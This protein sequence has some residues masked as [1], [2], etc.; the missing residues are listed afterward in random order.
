MSEHVQSTDLNS[1]L[2][3]TRGTSRRDAN[4]LALADQIQFSSILRVLVDTPEQT[5][6]VAQAATQSRQQDDR[7]PETAE[8]DDRPVRKT[9]RTRAKERDEPHARRVQEPRSDSPVTVAP[10]IT[11]IP[12]G[13][14]PPVDLGA[15][16]RALPDANRIDRS[17]WR[18]RGFD[19]DAL[20]TSPAATDPARILA[21]D[22]APDDTGATVAKTQQTILTKAV[23]SMASSALADEHFS[24]VGQDLHDAVMR[25]F[26]NVGQ[27][28]G[29]PTAASS[30]KDQQEVDL[31]SRLNA[32]APVAIQVDLAGDAAKTR[33]NSL[34]SL[35]SGTSLAAFEGLD[36]DA[37]P[38]A[39][40]FG[41]SNGEASGSETKA[42]THGNLLPDRPIPGANG[43][44]AS[45]NQVLRAQGALIA[46]QQAGQA[47]S[48]AK[49]PVL[50][51]DV[52]Q[53]MGAAPSGPSQVSQ[54]A[55][56]NA[57]SAARQPERPQPP[58][59]QIAVKIRQAVSEGLDKIN[60]KLNPANLGRVEVRLEIKDGHIAAT[61]LA[62]RKET[63]DLLQRDARGLERALLDAGLR[64]DI[65]S[66]SFGL[67]GD[68]QRHL[69][70]NRDRRGS[71]T[72]RNSDR[73]DGGIERGDEANIGKANGYGRNLRPTKGVDI[74]V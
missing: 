30:L 57:A 1:I 62:E 67:R 48:D 43:Q 52:I 47:G 69:D 25:K 14:E 11:T 33:S 8:R 35:A 61:V 64:T 50:P 15:L 66:L 58:A 24:T 10:R 44:D 26:A 53:N 55:K 46:A 21:A 37:Q 39:Q 3:V 12:E 23:A 4:N 20:E 7:R 29:A 9:E 16:P 68:G 56:A 34:H 59:E 22:I 41:R 54:T 2:D 51:S 65:Q 6:A 38:F 40:T 71:A 27:R 36:A 28:S 60:I 70:A 19:L 13:S 49:A 31:T 18:A 72:G 42:P 63:L 32:N 17:A 5:L 73:N 45:F 74:R